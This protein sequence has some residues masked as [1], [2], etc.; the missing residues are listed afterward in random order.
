MPCPLVRLTQTG[1]GPSARTPTDCG[2]YGFGEGVVGSDHPT[3][4][5]ALRTPSVSTALG[6]GPWAEVRLPMHTNLPGNQNRSFSALRAHSPC[7]IAPNPGRAPFWPP[8]GARR[9]P[10]VNSRPIRAVSTRRTAQSC[11]DPAFW[12]EPC[13]RLPD[14]RARSKAIGAPTR[15]PTQGQRAVPSGPKCLFL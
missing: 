1:P 5:S 3:G 14:G 12:A 10:G 15:S 6:W 11:I 4:R 9:D 2:T 8:R 13:W 7:R